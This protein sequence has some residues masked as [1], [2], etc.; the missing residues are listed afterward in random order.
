MARKKQQTILD[1]IY[2]HIDEKIAVLQRQ[3]ALLQAEEKL[4]DQQQLARRTAATPKPTR[5]DVTAIKA[6]A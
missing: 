4:Y 2:A 5:S 3:K 6:T 1:F